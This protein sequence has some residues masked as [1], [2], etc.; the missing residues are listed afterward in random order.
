MI[1]ILAFIIIAA[2]TAIVAAFL[3]MSSNQLKAT[4]YDTS[5]KKAFWA[6]EG[7]IEAV[8][9]NL[10]YNPT[11]V[12]GHSFPLTQTD[13][14]GY[15]TYSVTITKAGAAYPYTFTITSTGTHKGIQ[16]VITKSVLLSAPAVQGA[17]GV[18]AGTIT[19]NKDWNE[20][21]FGGI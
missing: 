14:Y 7:G 12:S 20:T 17:Y 1:L 18:T 19:V 6:A 8:I 16:S 9:Y 2:L 13:T 4:A 21:G 3:F 11:Y 10:K 15:A 5:A